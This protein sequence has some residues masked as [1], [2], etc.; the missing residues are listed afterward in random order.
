MCCGEP[1]LTSADHHRSCCHSVHDDMISVFRDMT[2]RR[3][4][5]SYAST[6]FGGDSVVRE[7]LGERNAATDYARV[8][9]WRRAY[10]RRGRRA[11]RDWPIHGIR[12]TRHTQ[13]GRPGDLDSRGQTGAVPAGPGDYSRPS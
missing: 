2:I 10:G 3:Y 4:T 13:A 1:G 9:E 8:R 12:T 6:T 5:G 11:V 7:G